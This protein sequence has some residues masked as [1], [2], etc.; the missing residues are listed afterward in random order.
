MWVLISAHKFTF[1][2]YFLHIIIGTDTSTISQFH[3]LEA[4]ASKIPAKW[5]KVGLSLGISSSI[6]DGIE[7][8]RRGDCLECFSDVF[9]YWQ[10][11]S[12]PQN[13]PNWTTLVTV[14]RS[15]YVGEKELSDTIHNTYV[16]HT[17]S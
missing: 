4:V 17:T 11:Q 16:S 14:L 7:K 2:T 5:R 10:Q 1:L 8:H 6:L 3:F 15:N 13:P 9:T 12:T